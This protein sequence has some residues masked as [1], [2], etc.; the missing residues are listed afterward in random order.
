MCVGLQA[1]KLGPIE[2]LS[3][4]DLFQRERG[5]MTLVELQEKEAELLEVRRLELR[6]LQGLDGALLGSLAQCFEHLF[7][8]QQGLPRGLA[9]QV[10]KADV[11][12]QVLDLQVPYFPEVCGGKVSHN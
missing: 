2:W 10:L 6:T 4:Q 5:S 9:A 8:Q 12:A 11:V 3:S 7:S 1:F